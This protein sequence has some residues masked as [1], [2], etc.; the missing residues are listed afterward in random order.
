MLYTKGGQIDEPLASKLQ[1]N[2]SAALAHLKEA[3]H[4][5]ES[6]STNV[7]SVILNLS[8]PLYQGLSAD[9]IPIATSLARSLE[10]GFGLPLQEISLIWSNW[11]DSVAFAGSN[12]AIDGG[13][14]KLTE[15]LY[16][17]ILESEKGVFRLN[18]PVSAVSR[19]TSGISAIATDGTQYF[20]TCALS[21]IPLGV[22]QKL[23]ETFFDPPL[24][25][26]RRN[27]LARTRVGV[28]EKV[29]LSYPSSWWPQAPSFTLLMDS[30]AI[31]ASP[32][33]PESAT[34][35]VYI[36][37]SLVGSS[38]SDIH[39]LLAS[40]IAPGGDVPDPTA[41]AASNWVNDEYSSGATSTPAQVGGGRS[42]LD[43]SDAARPIWDGVLG[44]SGE[45]TEIDQ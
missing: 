1:S 3:A 20:A 28:L 22:L 32:V 27:V 2:F 30:G 43:W 24:P 18:S 44:F 25:P 45:A 9:Q 15:A 5:S 11:S 33:S 42:P 4:A 29:A 39:Q 23:P 21:T 34:L 14:R 26:R 37:H 41:T 36:P 31:V 40:A 6:E 7:A 19:T 17:S 35:L 10:T 8:S 38:P 16:E 12:G 13:F